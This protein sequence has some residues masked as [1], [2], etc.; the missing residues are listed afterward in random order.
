MYREIVRT[1]TYFPIIG[2][3]TSMSDLI[4]NFTLV[5]YS[6][7]CVRTDLYL[8]HRALAGAAVKKEPESKLICVQSTNGII[9]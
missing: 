6:L 8:K 2:N 9:S 1:F 3:V 7:L 4:A 5:L